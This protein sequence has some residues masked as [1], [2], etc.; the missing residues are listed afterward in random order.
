MYYILNTLFALVLFVGITKAQNLVPNGDFEQY[1]FQA[2]PLDPNNFPGLD[3]LDYWFSPT[4][5]NPIYFTPYKAMYFYNVMNELEFTNREMKWLVHRPGT[6]LNGI[7][8]QIP[9]SGNSYISLL[10]NTIAGKP[11]STR[12]YISIKLT[13]KLESGKTYIAGM[14]IVLTNSSKR[15]V[16]AIGMH[17]SCD[18]VQLNKNMDYYIYELPYSAYKPQVESDTNQVY[19][20]TLN[21]QL[22]CGKFKAVGGEQFITIGNFRDDAH[23]IVKQLKKDKQKSLWY[24]NQGATYYIDDV[25]LVEESK[26]SE[27]EKKKCK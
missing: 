5:S 23:T 2:H 7:G 13:Q 25:F 16:N 10:T 21:W 17:V 9:H 1:D 19:S 20:D 22:V 4:V 6:P 12:S 3:G 8:Y 14:H 27:E 11:K 18:S 26:A 15:A 24:D